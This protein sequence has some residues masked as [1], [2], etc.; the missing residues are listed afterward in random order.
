VFHA[1]GA[2]GRAPG[3]LFFQNP[4]ACVDQAMV[5]YLVD[6]VT[7]PKGTVCQ[8]NQQPFDPDFGF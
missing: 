3:H 6:L 7:P 4:S 8:S 2:G 1:V 5:A